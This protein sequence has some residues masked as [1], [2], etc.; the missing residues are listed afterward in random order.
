[1][2]LGAYTP[3]GCRQYTKL[4]L[5]LPN[6]AHIRGKYP[7]LFKHT[8]RLRAVPAQLILEF[9]LKRG[10]DDSLMDSPVIPAN[11]ELS[12][13]YGIRLLRFS[14]NWGAHIVNVVKV[15]ANEGH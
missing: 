14:G 5:S 12:A 15:L 8:F 1:M 13:K 7:F 9:L 11:H 10:Q 2:Y 6:A 3:G 4:L